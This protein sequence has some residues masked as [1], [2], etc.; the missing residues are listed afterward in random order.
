MKLILAAIG[1]LISANAF[2]FPAVGDSVFYEVR[3][4]QNGAYILATYEL[5]I[6][7]KDESGNFIVKTTVNME[8][9]EPMSSEEPTDISQFL[10]LE[11]IKEMMKNCEILGGKTSSKKVEEQEIPTC[12]LQKKNE[13][14]QIISE[15]HLAE[16]PFGMVLQKDIIPD[17]ER[18]TT[19][20]MKKFT[21]GK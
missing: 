7:G 15:T 21:S 16:V 20:E 11:Q 3:T 2:A 4:E 6:T 14:G 18:V 19:V 17:I 8:D 9:N 10:N 12:I 5:E 1:A 13:K